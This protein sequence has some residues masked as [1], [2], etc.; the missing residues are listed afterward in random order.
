MKNIVIMGGGNGGSMSIRA[1]KRFSDSFQLT[2]VIGMTDSGGSSGRLRDEY[3]VLPPGDIL[4]AVLAMSRYDYE[5]FKHIFYEHRFSQAGAL[6]DHGLGHLFIALV[7]KFG[8]GIVDAIRALAQALDTIGP[9]YPVTTDSANLSVTLDDGTVLTGEAN[10]DRPA[11]NSARRIVEAKLDPA[12]KINSRAQHAIEDADAIIIGPG[13]FYTSLV[14]TLL[15]GGV[16][17]AIERSQ[18]KVIFVSGNGYELNGEYGPTKL[19]DF[20][21]ELQKFVPTQ[22]SAVIHNHATLTERQLA[23]YDEKK[24]GEIECDFTGIEDYNIISMNYEHVGGG[25]DPDK[26]GAILFNCI[27]QLGLG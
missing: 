22:F 21:L 19:C 4:R 2:A 3:G 20:V 7:E 14:A 16:A 23:Y 12:P 25:S 8:G 11:S 1:L 9:I 6:N 10:V 17:D 27:E 24:W 18:A 13:S 26:L 15:T 5:T